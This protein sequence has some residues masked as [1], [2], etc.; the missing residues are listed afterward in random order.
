[1]APRGFPAEFRRKVLDLLEAGRKVADVA[2]DLEISEQT[3]YS[4]RRQDRI[5]RG[6]Q[7]GTTTTE[8]SELAAAQR[9]IAQV[10]AELA[11]AQRALELVK[12][13]MPP[14]PATRPSGRWPLKDTRC[15]GPAACSGSP[16][17]GTTRG[18]TDGPRRVRCGTRT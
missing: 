4:W 7:A 12:G 18:Q 5:D 10:Q 3:I 8:K 15:S 6:L 2:R 17:P 1:M 16:S 9:T 11:A 13:V 14:K